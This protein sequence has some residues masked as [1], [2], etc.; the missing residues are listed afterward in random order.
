MK[1]NLK[2]SVGVLLAL[3][4][5][6]KTMASV[7]IDSVATTTSTCAN[8]GVATVYANSIP[9]SSLLYAIVSGPITSPIQNSNI[10]N[11]LFP[12]SYTVRVYNANFDS[13]ETQFQITG[14]YQLP[15]FTLKGY[16]PSCPTASDGSIYVEVDSTVGLAPFLYSIT[17]PIII[18]SQVQNSFLGLTANNYFVRITDACGNYQTRTQNLQASGT[19]LVQFNFSPYPIFQKLNCDS[20]EVFNYL[21]LDNDKDYFPF[22][23][24]YSGTSGATSDTVYAIPIDT[25][26][27]SPGLYFIRDTISG[28]DYGDFLSVSISDICGDIIFSQLNQLP[29][30]DFGF[31]FFGATSNCTT[32]ITAQ[33]GLLMTPYYPFFYTTTNDLFSFT[34][35]DVST[36]IIV[37]SISNVYLGSVILNSQIAGNSYDFTLTDNCG[38]IFQQTFTWP[39][40]GIPSTLSYY[41]PGCKDST[42]TITIEYRNFSSPVTLTFLSGPTISQ[43]TKPKFS[44]VDS[45]SYPKTFPTGGLPNYFVIRDLTAGTYTY[46]VSDSCGNTVPGTFTIDSTWVSN[47]QYEWEIKPSCLNDNT[48]FYNFQ[49]GTPVAISAT[50]YDLATGQVAAS[51]V[52]SGIRDSITNLPIGQYALEVYYAVRNGSGQYFD[53]S[54]V[55][56]PTDC[57]VLYDTIR[58]DPINTT[59]FITNNIIFCS[60]INYVELIL[61]S[62]RGVPPYK[63]EILSGPQTF[64]QQDSGIFQINS[65]GNY[66]ISVEDACG[67]NFT[68]QLSVSSDSFPPIVKAGSTCDGS[69]VF[70]YSVSSPSYFSYIW[71]SPDGTIYTGDTLAFTPFSVADTGLYI[72]T[73]IVNINGCNDTLYSQYYLS[74]VDKTFQSFSICDGDSILVGSN[75]LNFPG[76]YSDTLTSV[77]GCDS[78]IIST[79]TFLPLEVDSSSFQIC[80]GDSVNVGSNYY[81][82]DGLYVDT[83][84][85]NGCKKIFVT[86][87]SVENNRDSIS[88]SICQGETYTVGSSVYS[89]AGIYSDTLQAASGCD[90]IIVTLL[91]VNL[92]SFESNSYNICKGDSIQVG[93]NYYNQTGV[94]IDTLQ[95]PGSCNKVVTSNLIV[96][97][98]INS[99]SA[100]FCQGDSFAFGNAIITNAGLYT[101]SLLASNGCDSVVILS[102]SQTIPYSSTSTTIICEDDSVLFE[103][104]YYN[105]SG[106]FSQTYTS[107]GCDST[108]TLNLTVDPLPQ[109]TI[110]TSEDSVEMGESFDLNA[111]SNQILSYS[112]FGNS[113]FS[114]PNDSITS[115]ILNSSNWIYLTTDN[116]NSCTKSDSIFIYVFPQDGDSCESAFLTIPDVFTP[117]GDG[118]NDNYKLNIVDIVIDNFEIFDRWGKKLFETVDANQGWN[119]VFN[120]EK[121]TEGVY[122][123]IVNY[124]SCLDGSL[125]SKKSS[126]SLIR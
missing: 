12:G 48:F 8:N 88:A 117:N 84:F 16:D 114:T 110:T 53:G 96:S 17:A 37:D 9:V 10:F 99:F 120:S 1:F 38:H 115:A 7:T 76:V 29:P 109:F 116:S 68:Q 54:I 33:P 89:L 93:S 35:T 31:T 50:I 103:G 80:F 11:S 34:L 27:F 78:I 100:S 39:T 126:L 43:S 111:I 106:V 104:V 41:S 98:I 25:I 91:N 92:L 125:R 55:T 47:L 77:G 71:Q 52:L 2:L 22:V 45:I 107:S 4:S 32:T 65:F 82:V 46:E 94:Y 42:S 118:I 74:I 18:P 121:C 3:L 51:P 79:I 56:N 40:L 75:Y 62:S 30:F 113:T 123:C 122:F 73:K 124:R 81:S 13:T 23:I 90:S 119:G 95:V 85:V 19:G 102:L 60:G 97:E 21:Y 101:D 36:G 83:L 44:F 86:S 70:L 64:A 87:L 61:D 15:N 105:Q 20:M 26:N 6:T 108:I 28:Y 69:D 24:T 59:T 57:W 66:L 14:N 58:I 72:V 49:L 67:N 112:W 63:Y 5:G